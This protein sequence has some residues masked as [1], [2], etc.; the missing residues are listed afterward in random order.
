MVK[1]YRCKGGEEKGRH[2]GGYVDE[3]HLDQEMLKW[4]RQ[5]A[6]RVNAAAAAAL[7]TQPGTRPADPSKPILKRLAE[8]ARRQE[9]LAESMLDTRIPLKTYERLR[10]RYAE[11]EAELSAR[12]R[13]AQVREAR[14]VEV[15]NA[16]MDE[17]DAI[18]PHEKR[19]FVRSL[20]T[21]IEVTPGRQRGLAHIMPRD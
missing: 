5:Y 2:V 3:S 1:R 11:E 7:A 21:R 10:D 17:W 4:L 8:V 20:V 14:P 9:A 15:P 12:L 19:E 18:E 6:E 16:I 13:E